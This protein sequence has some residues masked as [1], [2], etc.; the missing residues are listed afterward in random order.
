MGSWGTRNAPPAMDDMDMPSHR[1]LRLRTVPAAELRPLPVLGTLSNDTVRGIRVS[2]TGRAGDTPPTLSCGDDWSDDGVN[3]TEPD[4]T[5]AV[6]VAGADLVVGDSVL[7]LSRRPGRNGWGLAPR[8]G[9]VGVV[10]VDVDPNAAACFARRECLRMSRAAFDAVDVG[11]CCTAGSVEGGVGTT[12][13]SS[14][15]LVLRA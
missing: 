1:S 7:S 4:V 9:F 13:A 2:T 15:G 14:G 5:A 10:G 8:R 3:G 6:G 11:G 12:T